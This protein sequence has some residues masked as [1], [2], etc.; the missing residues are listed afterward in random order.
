[1]VGSEWEAASVTCDDRRN[2]RVFGPGI[3]V[4]ANSINVKA[5]WVHEELVGPWHL[6]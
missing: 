2:L 4:A 3:Q 5:S 6:A 1:M